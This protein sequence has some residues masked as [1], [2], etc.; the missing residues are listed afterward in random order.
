MKLYEH[1]N[2]DRFSDHI[3]FLRHST[4][5]PKELQFD[6]V[7]FFVIG[8]YCEC[9]TAGV[10]C[11]DSCACE[12]CFNKPEYDDLVLDT[13]QQIESRNPLAFTS[14]IITHAT[15]SP[16]NVMVITHQSIYL[17]LYCD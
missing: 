14:K 15:D 6:S 1:I 17:V 5:K 8:S 4:F 3:V 7:V 9:F 2:E 11:V 12:N 16:E 13:R 10:Y